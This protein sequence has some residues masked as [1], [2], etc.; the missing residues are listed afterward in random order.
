MPQGTADIV[1]RRVSMF[2][3]EVQE[4]LRGVYLGLELPRS[5]NDF[6]GLGY[7][8]GMVSS[9]VPA[10]E[11]NDDLLSRQAAE[12]L[13]KTL[14]AVA[15]P[16]R[17]QLLSMLSGSPSGEVTVGELAGRLGLSQPTVSHHLRIMTDDGL[18]DREQR[19]RSVWYSITPE[20]QA[21]ISDL[22]R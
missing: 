1:Y 12:S 3:L 20:R 15:D 21:A 2:F 13:A 7:P 18:L 6:P 8:Y 19:G 16:T 5:P 11:H 14:R 22:M 4:V 17:L 10:A 9:D